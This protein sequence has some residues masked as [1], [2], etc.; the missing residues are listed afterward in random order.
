[1]VPNVVADAI[2]DISRS[3]VADFAAL[4]M[5]TDVLFEI[6]ALAGHIRRHFLGHELK[7]YEVLAGVTP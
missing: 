1:V 7:S 4:D 6:R 2:D 5:P 3:P